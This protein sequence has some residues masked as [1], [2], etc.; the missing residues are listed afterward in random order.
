MAS[1]WHLSAPEF[2]GGREGFLPKK[3][4][5]A[6]IGGGLTGILTAYYLGR[7]GI[8]A[9]V[10]EKRRPG[11]GQTGYTT[12]K[13]TC[14]RGLLYHKLEEERGAETVRIYAEAQLS[15]LE[16]YRRLTEALDLACDFETLPAVLYTQSRQDDLE[17]EAVSA[18]RAGIRAELKRRTDLPF[19][20]ALALAYPG[21]AQFH[22]LKFLYALSREVEL[23]AGIT[24]TDVRGHTLV[25]DD[26]Q[27]MEAERIVFAC[28]YPFKNLP[29]MYFT[30]L[31]QS[32]SYGIALGG[33]PP[34]S[35]M[36]YGIDPGGLSLRSHGDVLLLVGG[37]H[38]TGEWGKG[39]DGGGGLKI[40]RAAAN[41]YF[42]RVDVAAEWTGQDCMSPDGLP[43]IGEYSLLKPDWYV[44]TGFHKWGLLAAMV[45]ARLLVDRIAGWENPVAP[46]LRPTRF[47]QRTL[48]A[49]GE[50]TGMAIRGLTK[51]YFH[52]PAETADEIAPGEACVVFHRREK[53]AVHREQ[54]GE[55]R[56]VA[57]Y[58]THMG[59]ELTWN[60]DAGTWDCPCHGSRFSENGEVL[61][62]PAVKPLK[63]LS[64]NTGHPKNPSD[65]RKA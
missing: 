17:A 46:L 44:A 59:C 4:E 6:I 61:F 23:Y 58:C 11:D 39:K 7:S 60:P 29:G 36:Y 8:R 26:G 28:Q 20:V 52:A 53:A 49:V 64:G 33:I 16:E 42:P 63:N 51:H 15:A 38:R 65:E 37:A 43:L 31:Y 45:A 2:P 57:P 12:G 10:L 34:L 22:P 35:A 9:V 54:G 56:A 5:V 13:L 32:I 30:K 47:G 55:L 24:V 41:R 27:E 21:Q 40:L 50:E 19:D 62:S 3:T 48:R 25:C 14:Q 18:R 1:Y